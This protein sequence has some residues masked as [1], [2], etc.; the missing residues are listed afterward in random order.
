MFSYGKPNMQ[1]EN[2][3]T[4]TGY[5]DSDSRLPG[6]SL[7]QAASLGSFVPGRTANRALVR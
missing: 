3:H 2:V 4:C 1:N 6:H 5:A 7:T